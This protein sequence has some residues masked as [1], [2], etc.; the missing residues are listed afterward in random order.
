MMTRR[1]TLKKLALGAAAV[2]LLGRTLAS[3]AAAEPARMAEA[4]AP[5]FKLGVASY[6]LRSLPLVNALAG[7]RRVGL[8][9][10]S[11]N[12]AHLPW[13]NSPPGWEAAVKSFREA[14]VT[15]RCCGV[16]TLK[17]D[18]KAVRAVF[19]YAKILGVP[20]LA[21]S[22]EPAALPLVARCIQE[23]GILAAIHNHG[24]EDKHWPSPHEAWQA[25][26]PYDPRFGLCIDVGHAYRAGADPADCIRRYRERVHDIHLKDSVAAVGAAD[27]PVEV[28]RGLLDLRGILTALI[29]TGYS[30]L[31]WFEY[32]KDGND[33]LP[34]LA[35]SVGYV[36][37][38]L[39]GM[40][41]DAAAL[42]RT[43]S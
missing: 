35:E 19:E 24:P 38:L 31:V 10:I 37:G 27:T 30:R 33:P 12:R 43:L 32:E 11:V 1:E 7:V 20:V 41:L 23:Y 9:Y 25:I 21:C 13:E 8:N 4:L 29:D 42:S 40:G 36:R 14:G 26:Q 17:D 3:V 39:A 28:G 22:P 6:S 5:K 16:A 2:P 18:E 34:G 15:P